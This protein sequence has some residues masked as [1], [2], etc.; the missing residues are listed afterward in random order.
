M[1]SANLGSLGGLL[2]L[3]RGEAHVA[4]SHLLDPQSGE[5]NIAYIQ[6]YIPDIPVHVIGLAHREQGLVIPPENPQDISEL[7]DLRRQE[8]TFVNRQRGSGTR[9]LL[10]YHLDQLHIPVEDIQGYA[11]EEFTHLMVAASVASGRA[12]TGLAIR[13]AAEA[14]DLGF[15]PLYQERYDLIVPSEFVESKRLKLLMD[16][17]K[18]QEFRAAVA[19]LP[20]YDIQPMGETIAVMNASN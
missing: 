16:I 17:L 4:G 7:A 1:T 19:A 15:I 18:D 11:R 9:I 8:I 3:K 6:R 12:D 2:A 13:A 10:D 5:F 14:L 20:G